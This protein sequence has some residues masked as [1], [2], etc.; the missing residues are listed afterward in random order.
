LETIVGRALH[1]KQQRS[2]PASGGI[3]MPQ[4]ERVSSAIAHWAPRFLAN[5][6]SLTDF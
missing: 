3:S 2:G 4:D 6:V 1:S 5:G